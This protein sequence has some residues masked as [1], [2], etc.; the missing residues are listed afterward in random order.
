MAPTRTAPRTPAAEPVLIVFGDLTAFNPALT[1]EAIFAALLSAKKWFTTAHRNCLVPEAQIIFYQKSRGF[2]GTAVIAEVSRSSTSDAAAC[3][4]IPMRLFPYRLDL[5]VS[6][7]FAGYIDV[8]PLLEDLSF[9]KNKAKWGRAFMGT[10]R[11]IPQA[12]FQLII[13]Q[14]PREKPICF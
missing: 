5:K 7:Q 2:V 1:A 14:K 9:I 13:R 6:K 3:P 4:G 11:A 12:D 8:R 10:P